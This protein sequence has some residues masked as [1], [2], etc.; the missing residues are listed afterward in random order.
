[1]STASFTLAKP[2]RHPQN[3]L[4]FLHRV[5]PFINFLNDFFLCDIFTTTDNCVRPGQFVQAGARG[6]QF[7][8]EPLESL[9]PVQS[10]STDVFG[11]TLMGRW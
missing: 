11:L 2:H 4:K 3:S 1:M 5:I 9:F 8:V 10:T 6:T 7:A